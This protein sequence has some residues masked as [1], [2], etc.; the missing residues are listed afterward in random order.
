M[1]LKGWFKGGDMGLAMLAQTLALSTRTNPGTVSVVAGQS[2]PMSI[3]KKRDM[4][5]NIMMKEML[6]V[7]NLMKKFTIKLK[8]ILAW[9][10][11]VIEESN[12]Y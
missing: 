9:I 5:M 3:W 11:R 12:R 2:L 1:V 4:V 10:A 6:W 8:L 7:E